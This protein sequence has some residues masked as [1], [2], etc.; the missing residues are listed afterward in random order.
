MV[1]EDSV[2]HRKCPECGAV[3]NIVSDPRSG[4]WICACCGVVVDSLM[5]DQGPEWRA[6]RLSRR[7]KSFKEW[8]TIIF[9]TT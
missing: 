1:R 2:M 5:F 3:D 4:Q 7:A 6:Y 9:T 8:S